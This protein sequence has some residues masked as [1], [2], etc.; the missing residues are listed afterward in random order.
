LRPAWGF[1]NLRRPFVHR[2]LPC[3]DDWRAFSPC[4]FLIN[5]AWYI[6][7]PYTVHWWTIHGTLMTHARHIDEPYIDHA[8][9]IDDLC[10][11]DWPTLVAISL[12]LFIHLKNSTI[13]RCKDTNIF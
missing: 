6:D 5:H 12:R 3:A 7:E 4:G 9:Y 13:Y 10:M 1:G 11:V 8:R 2:A